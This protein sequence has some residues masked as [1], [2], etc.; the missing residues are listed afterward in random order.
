[1][2]TRGGQEWPKAWTTQWCKSCGATDAPA[3]PRLA[4]E[5]DRTPEQLRADGDAVPDMRMTREREGHDYRLEPTDDTIASIQHEVAMSRAK[6]DEREEQFEVPVARKQV[7]ACLSQKRPTAAEWLIAA[8][9]ALEAYEL[10]KEQE[11]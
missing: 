1:M 7:L 8:A 10:E 5:E 2:Y 9:L 6:R 3:L 11:R 4:L